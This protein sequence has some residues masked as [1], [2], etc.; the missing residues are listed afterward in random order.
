MVEKVGPRL[1]TWVLVVELLSQFFILQGVEVDRQFLGV[2]TKEVFVETFLHLFIPSLEQ[3]LSE[4][5]LYTFGGRGD[6][7]QLVFKD[8]FDV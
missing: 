3:C 4:W 8:L 5:G 1:K 6:V 7:Y 2:L